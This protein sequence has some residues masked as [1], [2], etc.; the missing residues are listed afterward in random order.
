MNPSLALIAALALAALPPAARAEEA[1]TGKVGTLNLAARLYAHALVT[2]DALA[3]VTAFRLASGVALR[4]ADGWSRTTETATGA[5]LPGEP[6]PADTA[7]AGTDAARGFSALALITGQAA[8]STRE[9]AAGDDELALMVEDAVADTA[10]GRIGGANQA[11]ATLAPGKKDIW[12]IPFAGQ[13]Q[14][15][16]GI[17]GD[18]SGGLGWMV[19][20]AQG[21]PVCVDPYSDQPLYCSFT[22]AENAFYTVTVISRA[23]VDGQYLLATN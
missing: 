22:P 12:E 1:A 6:A 19:A 11:V 10:R 9:I 14:A 23:D 2:D 7:Q 20:D 8:E 13:E 16:I 15:E 5:E 4:Q 21:V 3:A 17:F 18:G